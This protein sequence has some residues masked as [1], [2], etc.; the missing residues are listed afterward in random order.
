[1]IKEIEELTSTG[2]TPMSSRRLMVAMALFGV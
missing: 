1:M 2:S